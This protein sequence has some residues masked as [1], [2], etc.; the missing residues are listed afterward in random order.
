MSIA[1][2]TNEPKEFRAGV[3]IAWEKPDFSPYSYSEG[4]T[5]AYY[6][7]NGK[8]GKKTIN[9]SW[10]AATNSWTFNLP[11]SSND[12]AEGTYVLAGFVKIDSDNIQQVHEST[13]SIRQSLAAEIQTDT[14]TDTKQILDALIAVSKKRAT[15]EQAAQ[16]LPNGVAIS[17]LPW[18]DLI[19]AIEHYKYLYSQE[20]DSERITNGGSRRKILPTFLP[21]S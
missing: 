8:T 16:T 18:A 14:R 15:K 13:I 12:L 17:L 6:T 5:T 4:Y 19:K 21:T 7:I 3:N 1:L 9:G 11:A 20:L 2:S 10:S